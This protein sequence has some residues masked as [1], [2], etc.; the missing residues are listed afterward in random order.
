MNA[1]APSA[2]INANLAAGRMFTATLTDRQAAWRAGNYAAAAPAEPWYTGAA[3][4]RANGSGK[5][6]FSVWSSGF[7]S[8]GAFA[9]DKTSGA[10]AQNHTAAGAALGVDYQFEFGSI[11]V[12][13]GVSQGSFRAGAA[14]GS[15]SGVHLGAHA[16]LSVGGFYAAA[17][18]AGAAYS[19]ATSRAV[20][21]PPGLGAETENGAFRAREGRARLETG[22]RDTSPG[23]HVAPFAAVEVAALQSDH[24]VETL[25]GAGAAGLLGLAYAAQTTLS[26]MTSLGLKLDGQLVLGNGVVVTPSASLAW[27]HDLSPARAVKGSLAVL[28]GAEFRVEGAQPAANTVQAKLGVQTRV[29]KYIALFAAMEGEFSAKYRGVSGRGG[30]IIS[31]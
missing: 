4:Q 27:V 29:S 18:V 5:E 31:W 15:G 1:D 12:A 21:G 22:W 7:G 2:A 25:G 26:G 11:G 20:A 24:Y 19:N 13:G 3:R 8:I 23:L 28:P 30:A 6:G 14:T 17:S 9:A 16:G 10:S